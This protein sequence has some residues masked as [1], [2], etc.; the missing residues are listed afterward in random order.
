[1]NSMRTSPLITRAI[2]EQTRRIVSNLPSNDSGMFSNVCDLMSAQ[3]PVSKNLTFRIF[4]FL[5]LLRKG[6]IIYAILTITARNIF[7][8][9]NHHV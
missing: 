3:T 8:R 7:R 5:S 2:R 1:M 9:G 6:T 4:I